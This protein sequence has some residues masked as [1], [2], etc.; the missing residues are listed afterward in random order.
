MAGP[1]HWFPPAAVG[2]LLLVWVK[3]CLFA[4]SSLSFLVLFG[5]NQQ[6]LQPHSTEVSQAFRPLRTPSVSTCLGTEAEMSSAMLK[7]WKWLASCN[8]IWQ[9]SLWYV[10]PTRKPDL[11]IAPSCNLLSGSL[12]WQTSQSEHDLV[13]IYMYIIWQYTH[14]YIYAL[15]SKGAMQ[16]FLSFRQTCKTGDLQKDRNFGGRRTPTQ[17]SIKPTLTSCNL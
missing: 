16:Q 5:W 9:N 3:E 7:G 2:P 10:W 8:F 17:R 6:V 14:I 11:V 13:D 15:N 1:V 12:Q 4:E